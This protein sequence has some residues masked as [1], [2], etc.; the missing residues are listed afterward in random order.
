MAAAALMAALVIAAPLALAA[1]V[2]NPLPRSIPSL[3]EISRAL[4][5]GDISD[6]TWLKALAVVGWVAWA[7]LTAA[8]A[9]ELVATLRGQPSPRV[10]VVGLLQGLAAA[11]VTAVLPTVAGLGRS[12]TPDA[13]TPPLSASLP[14]S[15]LAGSDVPPDGG[16][17][18]EGNAESEARRSVV[19]RSADVQPDAPPD[20][21]RH[22]VG[23]RE[24]LWSVA[25]VRLGDALRWREIYAL[26]AGRTQWDGDRL[27]SSDQPIREGWVL[28]LPP[29]ARPNDGVA[30]QPPPSS[31]ADT[32]EELQRAATEAAGVADAAEAEWRAVVGSLAVPDDDPLPEPERLADELVATDGLADDAEIPI[33]QG[34]LLDGLSGAGLL[35][36]G[37]VWTL[38]RIRGLAERRRLPG[39]RIPTRSEAARRVEMSV[40]AA[41]LPDLVTFTDLALRAWSASLHAANRMAPAVVGINVAEELSLLFASPDREPPPGFTVEDDGLSWVT[42]MWRDLPILERAA[43]HAPAAPLPALVTIGHTDRSQVLLNLHALGHLSV[44]GDDAEVSEAMFVM[45]TELVS[46]PWREDLHVMV[47][48]VGSE[49]LELP[50]VSVASSVADLED[51]LGTRGAGAPPTVV[52]ALDVSPAEAAR[53]CT[54]V[55]AA[56]NSRVAAVIGNHGEMSDWT[57]MVKGG[58]AR[59]EPVG[60]ELARHRLPPLAR[61]VIEELVSASPSGSDLSSEVALPRGAVP[62][63]D[64]E[65]AVEV[66]V[67]GPVGVAG[68]AGEFPRRKALELVTYLALH[69]QGADADV[70]A[71]AL[72]PDRLTSPRTLHGVSSLARR[73]LGTSVGGRLLLP[74]ATPDGLYQLDPD[75]S[76]DLERFEA[77][78][79]QARSVPPD[80]AA[81]YLRRALGLVR[82]RPFTVGGGEYFWV[83]AEALMSAVVAAIA[84]AAH[85]LAGLCLEAGDHR[86]AWWA[87]QQGLL[88]SPGNEQLYRDRMAAADRAG[89]PAGVEAV[90]DE[91]CRAVEVGPGRAHEALHP[92]TVEMYE[93]L[94]RRSVHRVLA[95]RV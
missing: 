68:A 1:W 59:L 78:V 29:D 73:A 58:E 44:V 4:T 52:L 90:M 89:N 83:H 27:S 80:V 40:R 62:V 3:A 12:T 86:G 8:L 20:T 9:V 34:S 2:G 30:D 46:G 54:L 74:H 95:S 41:S 51:T 60:V 45:A 72:W 14:M 38:E 17:V 79:A 55:D 22:V 37:L 31:P 24:T 88:A 49:L 91:L 36:G 75:V 92:M 23:R 19:E 76:L 53:L 81:G 15:P 21:A 48:G 84:D 32:A 11:I 35:A 6:A 47:V 28:F 69:R 77:W 65:P 57:L 25:E 87:T 71:E 39:A 18:N 43:E 16:A 70:V 5:G 33:R 67:L 66:Q 50:T 93:R 56:A 26:N 7:E 13:T 85:Q 42:S 63:G 94:T 10:P 64:D 82:G 61:P